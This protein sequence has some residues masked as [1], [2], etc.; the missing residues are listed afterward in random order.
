MPRQLGT[1][2]PALPNSILSIDSLITFVQHLSAFPADGIENIFASLENAA[3][4]L[5]S[6]K[7]TTVLDVG[8]SFEVQAYQGTSVPDGLKYFPTSLVSEKPRAVAIKLPIVYAEDHNKCNRTKEANCLRAIAWEC[9]VLCHPPIRKCENIVDFYG[10]TWR[11]SFTGED[12]G[13]RF[14]PALVMEL[15]D[16]GVLIELFNLE[17]YCLIYAFK[18][19][20]ALDIA[21]GLDMLHQHGIIHSDIKAGNIFLF[22]NTEAALTAK[23]TNSDSR[24]TTKITTVR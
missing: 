14:L 8:A 10:L 22:S 18:W 24:S 11:T 15:S 17:W 16:E 13:A 5:N 20:L 9:H 6:D 23:V 4:L 1:S 2:G 21:Q 3:D 12:C 19:K 7:Q